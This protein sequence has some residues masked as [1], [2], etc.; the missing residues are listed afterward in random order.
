MWW[1]TILCSC[2]LHKKCI[3]SF[4]LP[5]LSLI[6]FP[7]MLMLNPKKNPP[8]TCKIEGKPSNQQ[9]KQQNQIRN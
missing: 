9:N 1:Y 5:C 6:F 4:T 8:L 2:I 3:I 7:Y